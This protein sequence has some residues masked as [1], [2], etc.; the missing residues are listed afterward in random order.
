[1][2]EPQGGSGHL[3]PETEEKDSGPED[4]FPTCVRTGLSQ[5]DL[6]R[7]LWRCLQYSRLSQL[8]CGEWQSDKRPLG[9]SSTP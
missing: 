8:E 4:L 3:V 7:D 5:G 2:W 6:P 9:F 1:M